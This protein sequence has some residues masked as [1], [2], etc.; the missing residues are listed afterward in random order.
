M[1]RLASFGRQGM[2]NGIALPD[3]WRRMIHALASCFAA[4]VLLPR[5]ST[6]PLACFIQTLLV[7]SHWTPV[8]ARLGSSAGDSKMKRKL[9]LG[10]E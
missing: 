8:C 3:H 5:G 9:D 4:H 7:N 6:P 10:T 2:V 1:E